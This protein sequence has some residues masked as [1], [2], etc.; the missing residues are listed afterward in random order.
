MSE[1]DVIY[2]LPHNIG[3]TKKTI[4]PP[5]HG[6]KERQYYVVEVAFNEHNPIH[7]ALFYSGFLNGG[8]NEAFPGGV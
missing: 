1:E 3:I 2:P 6:W 4:I 5:E 8:T 7:K